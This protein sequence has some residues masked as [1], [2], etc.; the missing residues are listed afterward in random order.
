MEFFVEESIFFQINGCLDESEDKISKTLYRISP[1]CISL[2][3][4]LRRIATL[5]ALHYIFD[6]WSTVERE[7]TY[8]VLCNLLSHSMI[9]Y[10]IELL[11]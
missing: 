8:Q 2:R 5:L 10:K 9:L 1:L 3:N 4:I 7:Q 11:F 6:F